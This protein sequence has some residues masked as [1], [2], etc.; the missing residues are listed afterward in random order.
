MGLKKYI[1][2]SLLLII[3]VSLYIYSVES[4]SYEIKVLDY[5]MQLP[6]VLWVIIPVLVLFFFSVLH[7]MFYSSLNFLKAR[8]FTKDEESI[9][10]TIKSLLL[11][12]EEKRR[13]KTKGYKRLA[14]ILKQLDVSV[15]EGTFTSSNEELNNIVSSIKDIEAGKYVADK[16]LKLNPDSNLAKKNLINKVNEQMDYAVDVLKKHDNF[17][18]EVVKAAFYT[19]LEN[20]SMTTVKKVYSDVKLTKDMALKLFLKDID[21]QEFGL[22]KEEIQKITKSLNYTEQEF[23]IL[24]KLYK[25]ALNPDKLLDLFETLSNDNETAAGAYF[26][27][28]LELEMIE[29]LKDLLSGY[30]DNEHKAIRAVLDLKDAGKHYSLEDISKI[31]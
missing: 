5:T 9:V 30:N 19:V 3:A 2:F 29:K 27:I 23:L 4:G 24:A 26:Y 18:E 20:K 13:F 25:D 15:K 11:Q 28:L 22:S 8:N 12:K 6:I 17:S 31:N 21:N 16:S 1:G 7:L 14:S 10:E